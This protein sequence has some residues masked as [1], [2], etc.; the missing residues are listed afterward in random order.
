MLD[1]LEARDITFR[2]KR[3]GRELKLRYGD[4]ESIESDKATVEDRVA[5]MLHQWLISNRAT[6]QALVDALQRVK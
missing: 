5:A 1:Y 4:L 2:W 3:I 6:K